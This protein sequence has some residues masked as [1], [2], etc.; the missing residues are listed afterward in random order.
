MAMEEVTSPTVSPASEPR[1]LP[2]WVIKHMLNGSRFQFVIGVAQV[3]SNQ[4]VSRAMCISEHRIFVLNI[5][6]LFFDI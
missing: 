3:F 5:L 1:C 4:T 6:Y 2:D